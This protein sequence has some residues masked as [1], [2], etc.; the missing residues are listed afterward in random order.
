MLQSSLTALMIERR[1]WIWFSDGVFVCV[2]GVGSVYVRA[3]CICARACVR[4]CVHA[5]VRACVRVSVYVCALC[6]CVRACMRAC[7]R[8]CVCSCVLN[9]DCIFAVIRDILLLV[10]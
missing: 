9:H 6:I 2:G 4:Q 7:V 3:L 8:V 10:C 1:M 5:C